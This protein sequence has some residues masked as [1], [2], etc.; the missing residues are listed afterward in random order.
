MPEG[1]LRAF[2]SY[3]YFVLQGTIEIFFLQGAT[4]LKKKHLNYN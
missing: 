1:N 2:F 3:H 4:F